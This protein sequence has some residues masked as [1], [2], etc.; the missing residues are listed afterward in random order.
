MTTSKTGSA[1][2]VRGTHLV[3]GTNCN[4]NRFSPVRTGN[5]KCCG[6]RSGALA[7]QPRAYGEHILRISTGRHYSGSA[8]CVRGTRKKLARKP[9]ANRF[10]PVRTGNTLP[11]GKKTGVAA[12]QPRAYGEHRP[13]H[14]SLIGWAGSA[15]CVRGTPKQ[16][17][18][19]AGCIWFS[20]VRTGN[21]FNLLIS[22]IAPPVQ[23]RAY[24]EHT[25]A[26][27]L[28]QLCYGSAPCVRGTL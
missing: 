16:A 21:T 6:G 5:T 24:G 13:S 27:L 20:P 25:S 4:I 3:N 18:K 28:I 22:N 15:P 23:P 11:D 12:V 8:P 7:V 19:Q 26:E 17:P 1:P 9:M 10:S 2:C 14:N